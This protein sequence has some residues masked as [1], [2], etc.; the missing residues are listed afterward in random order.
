MTG[1]WEI[2]VKNNVF[3][4]LNSVKSFTQNKWKIGQSFYKPSKCEMGYSA[5]ND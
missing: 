5:I 3:A 4:S 2:N 1:K